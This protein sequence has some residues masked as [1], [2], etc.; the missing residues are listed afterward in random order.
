MPRKVYVV[1]GSNNHEAHEALRVF[2]HE[3]DAALYVKDRG[4]EY[5]YTYYEEF[6]VF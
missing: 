6:E 3:D 1:F 4:L 5:D 2:E